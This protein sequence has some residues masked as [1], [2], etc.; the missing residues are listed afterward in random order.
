MLG[1]DEATEVAEEWELAPAEMRERMREG[2]RRTD[3]RLVVRLDGAWNAVA[4]AGPDAV[5]QAASSAVEL[6]DWTLRLRC[7]A[8]G[9]EAWV[10]AQPAAA[11]AERPA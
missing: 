3:P 6:V 4:R 9:L 11:D 8:A 2:L 7:D 5:S 10:A 1:D